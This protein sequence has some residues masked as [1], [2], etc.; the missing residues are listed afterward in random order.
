VQ[1]VDD[2]RFVRADRCWFGQPR[3]RHRAHRL[4]PLFKGETFLRTSDFDYDPRTHAVWWIVRQVEPGGLLAGF[5]VC[6]NTEEARAAM[7]C[8][9]AVHAIF[10]L[11]T[12]TDDTVTIGD[13]DRLARAYQSAA[14]GRPQ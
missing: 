13:V 4:R 5:T 8:E 2:D 10:D 12:G 3:N 14:A 7:N 6:L 11:L 1:L 9:V